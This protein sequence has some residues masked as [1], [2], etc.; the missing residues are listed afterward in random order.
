[1]SIQ[2][3]IKTLYSN[4]EKTEALC[5]RTKVNAVSDENGKLEL[6]EK[7]FPFELPYSEENMKWVEENCHEGKPEILDRQEEIETPT[8][9]DKIEAQVM[10]NSI[11]LGTLIN[12]EGDE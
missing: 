2:G 3:K 7:V 8:Q 10:Y 12:T 5:P 4:E 1:M 6:K 9:L 11:M